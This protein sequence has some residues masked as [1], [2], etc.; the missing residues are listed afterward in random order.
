MRPWSR[1]LAQQAAQQLTEQL[2]EA[3]TRAV[4]ES[5][6]YRMRWRPGTGEFQIDAPFGDA[7]DL[8]LEP[9]G[10][11]PAAAGDTAREAPPKDRAEAP[12]DN[13]VPT[14]SDVSS[15]AGN[16]LGDSL[17][18]TPKPRP[19]ALQVL[20]QLDNGV[21]FPAAAPVLTVTED[22]SEQPRSQETTASPG[23]IV[24][25]LSGTAIRRR[26]QR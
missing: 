11:L 10:G 19:V 15:E 6:V 24:P 2:L 21:K 3:R 5:R 25:P 16:N 8:P 26:S 22:S 12:A 9:A 13:N 4:E 17:N 23:P 1:S 20:E 7:T 14:E 18:P